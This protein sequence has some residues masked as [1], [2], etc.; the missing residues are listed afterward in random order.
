M[1]GAAL[2]AR[3]HSITGQKELIDIA[4]NSI[5]YS[6]SCQLPDGA[7]YYGEADTYHWIDNWHTAY[8][9][10]SLLYYILSSDDKKFLP[11]LDRGYEFYK[12]N[13]FCKDG[14][15]KYYHNKLYLIDIQCAS[16]SIDT[17]SFFSLKDPESINQAIKIAE[18]TIDN[19]QDKHG[20]FYYRK[21]SW[22]NVKIPMIHWGLATMLS[23]LSHL[24]SKIGH[25]E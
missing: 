23:A 8:N 22:K 11:N 3:V 9:L 7:W 4:R 5:S 13:F 2:L 12:M 20:F 19:M 16:Q 24:Y 17:L 25:V 1:I 18:W 6:C 15:P 21:L 10:D 14:R